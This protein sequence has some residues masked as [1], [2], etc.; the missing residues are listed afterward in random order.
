MGLLKKERVQRSNVSFSS[1]RAGGAGE[2]TAKRI[3]SI[4]L[5]KQSFYK[6]WRV[7]HGQ[8]GGS[9]EVTGRVRHPATWWMKLKSSGASMQ[10]LVPSS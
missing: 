3:N 10:A 8:G 4:I 7:V 5:C 1:I 6:G 9:G 2:A